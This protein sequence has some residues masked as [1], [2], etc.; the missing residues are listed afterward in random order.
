MIPKKLD[1]IN[2]AAID[3]LL[4]NAVAEGKGVEYKA[5][6]P[7]SADSDKKEFL[8]DVSSF[9]NTRGGDLFYGVVEDK[10]VPASIPGVSLPDPDFEIRRLE[11]LINDGLDPRIRF[12]I[13]L[14]PR[15]D[16]LP[17][18]V[19]RVER[20]WMGPHRVEK[21][22]HKFYARTSTGKYPMDVA[23]LRTAFTLSSTVTE[24]VRDF[25]AGRISRLLDDRTPIAFVSGAKTLLHLI[26]LESLAG[27]VQYDVLRFKRDCHLF[28]PMH[29]GSSWG[30]RINLDG[31]V[32]YNGG[33]YDSTSYTQIFRNGIVEAVEGVML[34]RGGNGKRELVSLWFEKELLDCFV[35]LLAMQKGL[36]INPPV[37][38][39]LT[40][41]DTK[42]IYMPNPWGTSRP[43]DDD[44]LILP[45]SI[46]E[47]F[48]QPPGKVLKPI[49]D[50]I[51][52]ACGYEKSKNFDSEG[53]WIERP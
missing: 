24:R 40:L 31:V 11:S 7:G 43:I 23:E 27:P 47:D 29:A 17:V 10:G 6:L 13:R 42:G 18:L 44:H 49:F 1:E 32:I 20:S 25:R 3:E 12:G 26:P 30:A 39:A 35:Q 34:N 9:A 36:G 50:L 15:T 16:K 51:W 14:V 33:H 21:G 5:A 41:T 22:H 45:E 4:T 8:A 53:N 48:A 19:I 46:V 28:P 52:N 37:A 38:I 2:E